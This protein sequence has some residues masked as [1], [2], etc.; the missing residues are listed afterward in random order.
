MPAQAKSV[1][2][3]AKAISPAEFAEMHGQTEAEAKCIEEALRAGARPS[4]TQTIH[5]ALLALRKEPDEAEQLFRSHAA[6]IYVREAGRNR[7][8]VDEA[9][10]INNHSAQAME[11]YLAALKH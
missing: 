5:D 8:S 3:H 11:R 4:V 9:R 6:E 1:P 10:F 7:D 2:F